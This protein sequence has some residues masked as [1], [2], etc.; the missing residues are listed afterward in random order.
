[1]A[2]ILPLAF[3][4]EFWFGLSISNIFGIGFATI[5]QLFVIPMVYL[6]LE[7]KRTLKKLAKQ[8]I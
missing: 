7:G 2:G 5:L 3:T 1:M 4:D 8:Q 6:K